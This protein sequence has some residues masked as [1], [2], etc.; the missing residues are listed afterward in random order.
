MNAK[1][2]LERVKMLPPLERRRFFRGV[3]KLEEAI[4]S[5]TPPRFKRPV[6]WPD[7]AERRRKIFGEKVFPNMVLAERYQTNRDQ[8][9]IDQALASGPVTP[10]TKKEMKA[11]RDRV[12]RGKN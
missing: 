5:Q 8:K 10:L 12:L 11:I 1:V 3:H 4:E 9:L 6:R 7:A 2:L